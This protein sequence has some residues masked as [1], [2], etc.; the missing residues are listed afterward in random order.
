MCKLWICKN[1]VLLIEPS[2]VK[3]YFCRI[4]RVS[5]SGEGAKVADGVRC[6]YCGASRIHRGDTEGKEMRSIVSL[7]ELRRIFQ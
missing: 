1:S 7:P 4:E 5:L 3:K 2:I 6:P